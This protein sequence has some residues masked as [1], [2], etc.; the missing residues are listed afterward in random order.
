MADIEGAGLFFQ[1]NFRKTIFR[2]INTDYIYAEGYREYIYHIYT[3]YR[4][5]AW[6][7]TTHSFPRASVLF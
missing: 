2:R 4:E 1:K 7:N 5:A 3:S 6:L